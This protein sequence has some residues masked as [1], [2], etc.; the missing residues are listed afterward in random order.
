MVVGDASRRETIRRKGY[1]ETSG[2]TRE[3]LGRKR[4]GRELEE[5]EKTLA[6]RKEAQGGG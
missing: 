6:D 2:K 1:S 5:P 4:R 3:N